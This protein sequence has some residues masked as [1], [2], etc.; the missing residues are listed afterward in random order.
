MLSIPRLE[1]CSAHLLAQLFEYIIP[2]LKLKINQIHCWS[3]S[4]TV[5][6]WLASHPSKWKTFD[7]HRTTFGLHFAYILA[8]LPDVKWRHVPTKQNP[9][10]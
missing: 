3:D 7:S 6:A 1:L 10:D 2:V 5:L 4:K 8:T 9:A